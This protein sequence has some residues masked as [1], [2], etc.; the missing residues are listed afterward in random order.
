VLAEEDVAVVLGGGGKVSAG[1]FR[2]G[3]RIG[4]TN[5]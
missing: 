3:G 4:E 5:G 2:E 1:V